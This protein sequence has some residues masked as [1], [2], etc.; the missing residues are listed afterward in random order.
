MSREQTVIVAAVT[1]A[2]ERPVTHVAFIIND[3]DG[4]AKT[5]RY[6]FTIGEKAEI[7]NEVARRFGVPIN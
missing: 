2:I 1:A 7:V 4:W 6:K 3:V 5:F